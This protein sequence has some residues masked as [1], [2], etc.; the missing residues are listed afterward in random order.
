MILSWTA[1]WQQNPSTHTQFFCPLFSFGSQTSVAK[2]EADSA[3]RWRGSFDKIIKHGQIRIYQVAAVVCWNDELTRPNSTIQC[4]FVLAASIFVSDC[5]LCFVGSG[6]DFTS[7]HDII[8][9]MQ[10][11]F[12]SANPTRTK[13][14]WSEHGWIQPSDRWCWIDHIQRCLV[15]RHILSIFHRL[16]CSSQI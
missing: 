7:V 11:S 6:I 1:L 13:G 4:V 5:L 15:L 12:I 10:P 9:Y 2:R 3:I 14:K 8:S 16:R